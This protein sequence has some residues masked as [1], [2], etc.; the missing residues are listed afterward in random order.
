MTRE[1]SCP[2]TDKLRQFALGQ[3]SREELLDLTA[4]I[5]HCTPCLDRLHSLTVKD[6]SGQPSPASAS[7]QTMSKSAFDLLKN[8]AQHNALA[9]QFA[10]DHC[11]K[12]LKVKKEWAGKRVKCS[13]C[14]KGNEVPGA[15]DTIAAQATGV[16]AHTAASAG[17]TSWLAPPEAP[18]ELGRLGRYR[19][20]RILGSG[21]MG[22]V[23]EAYDPLLDRQVAVKIARPRA[24][25]TGN[26]E[27]RFLREAR[28]AATIHH[29]NICPV[30]EVGEAHGVCFIVMGLIP[31]SSLAQF[32]KERKQPLPARQVVSLVRKLALALAVAHGKG[33]VHRD[34]KPS[35][36]MLDRERR[37]PVIMD[38]GLARRLQ[39]TD[40][41]LTHTGMIVGT[42]AYMAPE[43][44]L[45]D[46]NGI[47]PATDIYAL[48]VILYELLAGRPPFVGKPASVLGE[49]LFA[50]VE[51]P[52]TH[53]S[54]VNSRL[55][56][57]CLKA[58]DRDRHK[59][60]GSMKE[61]AEDLARAA[62]ELKE[63]QTTALM[64]VGSVAEKVAKGERD[65]LDLST[66]FDALQAQ[67]KAH[68]LRF[69]RLGYLVGGGLATLLFLLAIILH[70]A[71]TP[72][73]AVVI[74]VGV[75][76]ADT[77]LHF[78]LDGKPILAEAL[79]APL[80]L[81]VGEHELIVKREETLVKRMRFVVQGG[82]TP[83]V[84]YREEKKRPEPQLEDD[85]A[86]QKRVALLSDD[87]KLEAVT[88]RLKELN[89]G[90]DG[91]VTA[92][93]DNGVATELAFTTDQVTNISPV[94][95]LT[96]LRS[97]Q[98]NSAA[99][100]LVDLSPLRDLQLDY[101]SCQGTSVVDLSPLE[102]MPLTTL[103][104]SHSKVTDLTPLGKLK[105]TGL[106]CDGTK[107]SD[108]KP[109]KDMPLRH[110]QCQRTQITDFAPLQSTPLENLSCGGSPVADLSSLKG[111]P[112]TH[113]SCQDS[114]VSDLSPLEGMKL[115]Q[116]HCSGTKVRDLAPLKGMPLT[117]LYCHDTPIVD[118]SPLKGML[119]TSL[120]CSATKVADLTPLADMPLTNLDCH[121]TLV[122][123]L[124]PLK[125]VPLVHFQCQ[126]TKVADLTP[127]QAAPLE[128]LTCADTKVTLL[129]TLKTK[130]LSQLHCQ[131]TPLSDLAPL[132]GQKL[133]HLDCSNTQVADLTPLKGMPLMALICDR[134]NVRDLKPLQGL[135]LTSLQINS[136]NISDLRPLAG[137]PLVVLNCTGTAV[138][139][140]S[141]LKGM[142]LQQI[143]CNDTPLSDLS[144]LQGMSL[145]HITLHNTAVADLSPLAGMKLTSLDCS[146]TK[147]SDL[148]PLK[149]MPL[150]YFNCYGTGVRDLAPLQGMALTSLNCSTT[151]VASL[152]PLTGMPLAHLDCTATKVSDL[153]P[154]KS[155]PLTS[156]RFQGALVT[157][158]T[159]LRSIATLQSINDAAA[160]AF[161]K[162]A[163]KPK[164]P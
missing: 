19:L 125:N 33:I 77:T 11:G 145:T 142:K 58:M 55:E 21:G 85:D 123:D 57:I 156:I 90:F 68:A 91:K 114:E 95:V 159:P 36:I 45:G 31:G 109:L 81:A 56:R 65:D 43:Q 152:A 71:R 108:L 12:N 48:G 164:Q 98:L 128:V 162:D 107:V 79:A 143:Q 160:A 59:R 132:Q 5:K 111:V 27:E 42:P 3:V 24:H 149:R 122:T 116:L 126:H 161:W 52:S 133:T 154:L 62:R 112:L 76:L 97:L 10:C 106:W 23:Y 61:L 25:E 157:D 35:N 63:E 78:I 131:N 119:L 80:K 129:P 9:I 20:I 86:W 82:P 163:E 29:A 101:L 26:E 28:A 136:T 137:M 89:R 7:D 30:Y 94:R 14:G 141:P 93:I 104:C 50:P 105:L 40:A 73:V 17:A 158:P 113:F 67:E 117:Q 34:L 2:D 44:A 92:R 96:G 47:G 153:S 70:F 32:A 135:K 148:S 64:P 155:S 127:L 83:T 74:N 8:R 18:G 130:K 110:L 13:G 53:R 146:R 46:V 100:K 88:A 37:E 147:I 49:V 134:T 102:K 60:Y 69:R 121:T 150:T 38:F 99:G 87:K 4:H 51:P 139:D 39:S 72:T 66:L 6:P 84:E 1:M 54:G 140:L 75:D 16:L 138:T 151:E 118:L 144:G 124:A 41:Q 115:I 22:I 103:N 15:A 120:T